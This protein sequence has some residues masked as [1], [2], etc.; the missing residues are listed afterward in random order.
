MTSVFQK[1]KSKIINSFK[2]CLKTLQDY[3]TEMKYLPS[4]DGDGRAEFWIMLT[5]KKA[6]ISYI[7]KLQ[8]MK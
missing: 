7:E 1:N 4:V 3:E 8:K 6:M 2:D 5:L